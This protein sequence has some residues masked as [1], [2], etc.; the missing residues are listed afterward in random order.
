MNNPLKISCAVCI[1]LLFAGCNQS[2]SPPTQ[3]QT[4]ISPTLQCGKDSD[5]KGDR[6]CN[7]GQC[8][9]PTPSTTTRE[10]ESVALSPQGYTEYC[11]GRFG[12]CVIHPDNIGI[13]PPPD[14]GDGRRFYDNDGFVMR[15][16]GYYNALDS[17][18]QTEIKNQ[19]KNFEKITYQA[20]GKNWFVLSGHKGADTLYVKTFVGNGAINYLSIEYPSQLKTDYDDMVA[21]IAQSF[22]PGNIND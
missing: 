17:T 1:A 20:K 5:C 11:N 8:V 12:F 22:K 15:V 21:K 10:N 19:S 4:V 13:A 6:I 14:N 7:S 9:E 18:L 3:Q 2:S 16:V